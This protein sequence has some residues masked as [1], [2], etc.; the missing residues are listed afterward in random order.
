MDKQVKMLKICN[1]LMIASLLFSSF[2]TVWYIVNSSL[3][4]GVVV[5][6]K[7]PYSFVV[8]GLCFLTVLLFAETITGFLTVR[9]LAFGKVTKVLNSVAWILSIIIFVL[10]F[11]DSFA[12]WIYMI[13][14]WIPGVFQ[15][16]SITE[17]GKEKI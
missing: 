2:L 1:R 16:S 6:I 10:V 9:N 4:F 8:G 17:M 13:L 15:V 7:I 12:R 14:L 3:P 5:N 11:G